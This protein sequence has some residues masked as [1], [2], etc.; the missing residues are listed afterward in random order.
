MCSMVG[1]YVVH[2]RTPLTVFF[3]CVSR[4]SGYL[5]MGEAMTS[6]GRA[7]S[8]ETHGYE[9]RSTGDVRAD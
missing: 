3:R 9:V 5:D 2:D 4:D 1:M 6:P 8:Q 7:D